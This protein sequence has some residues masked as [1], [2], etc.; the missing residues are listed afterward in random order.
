MTKKLIENILNNYI[1]KEEYYIKDLNDIYLI[2][3]YLFHC[4]YF[5][6]YIKLYNLQIRDF[7]CL[8]SSAKILYGYDDLLIFKEGDSPLGFYIMIK[9]GIIS[10]ISKFNLPDKLDSFFKNEI[11]QE[12]NLDKD[13]EEITWFDINI[14]RQKEKNKNNEELKYKVLYNYKTNNFSPNS[15]IF[16]QKHEE[17]LRLSRRMSI[18]S[19]MSESSEEKRSL[20]S[21]IFEEVNLFKYFL[22]EED[23]FCFGNVNLFNEYMRE[24]KQIHLTSAYFQSKETNKAPTNNIILYIHEDILK[25][26]EKKISLINKERIKFLK[27]TLTPLKQV[28]ST[29]QNYFISTIK[30]IYINIENQKELLLNNKT[31][32]L[33]HIGSCCEK[34]KKEIIY[35]KGSFIGLN[36][37]FLKQKSNSKDTIITLTAKG[38]EVVLF[39][40]DLNFLP[41]NSQINMLKYLIGIFTKQYYARKIYNNEVIS[42]ENKKIKQKEKDLNFKIQDY[43][44]SHGIPNFQR[45]DMEY[46]DKNSKIKENGNIKS[47]NNIYINKNNI[48]KML[49]KS[50]EKKKEL[51]KKELSKRKKNRFFLKSRENSNSSSPRTSRST[52]S[53]LPILNQT[54][55][56][57]INTN[58]NPINNINCKK[59]FSSGKKSCKNITSRNELKNITGFNS[60]SSY[61]SIYSLFHYEKSFHRTSCVRKNLIN[62]KL[63]LKNFHQ[64]KNKKK[65][66]YHLF[67]ENSH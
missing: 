39:Q 56:S 22:N 1:K 28:F 46:I 53:T 36:N 25:D 64:Y 6:N 18:A 49:S 50:E 62:K 32:Y 55:N 34:N 20:S 17:R 37:L 8:I 2:S 33:V 63:L 66:K 47:L 26:F 12:Y 54:Q 52:S 44:Y 45:E 3:F 23:I 51:Y 31:F 7:L 29:Y 30:L 11:L 35:D 41:E 40:I 5:Q 21:I 65:S 58:N 42:Y 14:E 9:G 48:F 15:C 27:N 60:I 61:I 16:Q 19:H 57:L 4:K 59:N 67:I 10:K 38:G 24:Q 43:L 13:N